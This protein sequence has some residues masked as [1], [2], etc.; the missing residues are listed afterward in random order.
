MFKRDITYE[1][2]D[3]KEQ[4]ETFYFN[5]TKTELLELAVSE[6]GGLGEFL[7]RIVESEDHKEIVARF[8]MLILM[9]YGQRSDDRKRF[10]KSDE[11]REEFS[12]TAA[13]DVLFNELSTN[14]NSAADFVNGVIPAAMAEEA[15]KE[16]LKQQTAASLSTAP[17][18]TTAEIAAQQA[19]PAT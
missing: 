14:A 18:P 13:F 8:K 5:L 16:L 12:Q 9:S 7:E 10:I 19:P 2:F 6:K 3:G 17:A 11:L 1:D 15:Q 4:T